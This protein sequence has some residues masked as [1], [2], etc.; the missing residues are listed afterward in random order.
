MPVAICAHAHYCHIGVL[1]HEN[2]LHRGTFNALLF[3]APSV[4]QIDVYLGS[5]SITHITLQL[6]IK[7][8]EPHAYALRQV[9]ISEC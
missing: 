6:Q 8:S 7:N 4:G 5:I 1:K 3:H 9:N 2:Q